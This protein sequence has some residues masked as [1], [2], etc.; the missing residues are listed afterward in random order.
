MKKCIH[1]FDDF[2]VIDV[3]PT[4]FDIKTIDATQKF[5]ES[6]KGKIKKTKLSEFLFHQ[7]HKQLMKSY[8]DFL[9]PMYMIENPTGYLIFIKMLTV[10]DHTNNF[11]FDCTDLESTLKLYLVKEDLQKLLIHNVYQL[12]AD[13]NIFEKINIQKIIKSIKF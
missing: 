1:V 13:K 10:A 3:Y 7:N 4:D 2:D 8:P 5:K 12:T 6:Y 11:Y 9:L